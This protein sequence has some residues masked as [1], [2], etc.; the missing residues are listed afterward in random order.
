M[1]GELRAWQ[2]QKQTYPAIA[3]VKGR[4]IGSEGEAYH[5]TAEHW[6]ELSKLSAES[7]EDLK[8][9]QDVMTKISPGYRSGCLPLYPLGEEF[10]YY[11]GRK[12]Y[13]SAFKVF[14]T[15]ITCK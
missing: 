15:L 8:K 9:A 14:W 2:Y 3:N 1:Q 11:W 10:K 7:R 12:E 5:K 6:E 4:E 13:V